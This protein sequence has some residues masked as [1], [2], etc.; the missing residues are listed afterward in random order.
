L[1]SSETSRGLC[2]PPSS[3]RGSV[4][5]VAERRCMLMSMCPRHVG[6]IKITQDNFLILPKSNL[7]KY[8]KLK[9]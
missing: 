3:L 1:F 9:F 4:K 2:R 6:D 8:E 5:F 7:G